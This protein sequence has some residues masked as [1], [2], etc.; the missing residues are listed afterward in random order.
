L[1]QTKTEG[2][3]AVWQCRIDQL[4][5]HDAGHDQRVRR[6]QH[7]RREPTMEVDALDLVEVVVRPDRAN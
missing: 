1:E 2:F 3:L 4:A 7:M 5:R 6:W